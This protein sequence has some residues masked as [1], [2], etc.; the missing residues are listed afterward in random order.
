MTESRQFFSRPTTADFDHLVVILRDQLEALAPQLQQQGFTLTP[1][2]RHSL[3]SINQVVTL[4]DSYI[5]LLGWPAGTTPLR[6]E[7][8]HQPIGLDALVFRSYDAHK[9]YERLKK[10][11]FPVQPVQPLQRP[12]PVGDQEVIVQFATVRF[13]QQ[14]IAGMRLY[15]C[16]HLTPEYVWADEYTRHDNHAMAL[17]RITVHAPDAQAVATVLGQVAGVSPQPP[18]GQGS[19][20][21]VPLGNATIEVIQQAGLAHAQITDATLRYQDQAE[22]RLRQLLD[23]S[24]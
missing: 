6:E 24:A 1:L 9:T 23:L 13:A 8:A 20:W 7:I 2:A 4:Q 22:R 15:Y 19:H 16:Q 17:T 12:T 14:P 18:Q 3:G 21:Q 11:G 5:E 10:A